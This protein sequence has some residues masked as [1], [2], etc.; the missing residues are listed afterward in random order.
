MTIENLKN[1]KT[2]LIALYYPQLHAI[3]ENDEWWGDGFTDWVN[4]KKAMP[5][6]ENHNQPRI[7]LKGYYDQ[8][9]FE[10]VKNQIELA[11]KYGLYGFCHYHY[12]FDGKQLLETPTN[13]FLDNKELDFPFCLSWANETWSRRWDGKNHQILIQQTHPPEKERWALHFDYLIKAWRDERAIK[14]DGKPVFV[15]YRPNNIPKLEQ[16]LDFWREKAIQN[17]LKGLYFIVQKRTEFPPHENLNGF[18]AV[19]QFQPF[20]AIYSPGSKKT[21]KIYSNLIRLARVLPEPAQA[22]LHSLRGKLT[23]LTFYDYDKIW[24]EAI[25]IRPERGLTTFPGAFVDWDNTARY[26]SRATIFEGSTPERF[27]H[28]LSELVKTMPKRE[29]PEDFIFI[30]AWNEWAEGTYL[31]PDIKHGYKHLEV[32]ERVLNKALSEI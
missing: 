12:W 13:L 18:D 6:F 20:E 1:K 4:V 2:K 5:A 25:K 32:I 22:V 26:K 29:L 24:A 27:E 30:N 19:F 9:D 23:G 21:S 10:T 28:W 14:V 31:E 11:K 17:G 15:I 3:P 16:M 7:P 8:A